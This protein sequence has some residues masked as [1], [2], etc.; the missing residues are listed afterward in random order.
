MDELGYEL[1]DEPRYELGD[2]PGYEL[3]VE[4]GYELKDEEPRYKP[5][6]GPEYEWSPLR[7]DV[8]TDPSVLLYGGLK[9]LIG[10]VVE[11]NVRAGLMVEEPLNVGRVDKVWG[12]LIVRVGAHGLIDKGIELRYGLSVRVI[13]LLIV[14][15]PR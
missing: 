3:K 11:L 8:R 7:P 10:F 15:L 14:L 5:D 2:E 6:D 13:P 4:P 9:L 12:E 1:R